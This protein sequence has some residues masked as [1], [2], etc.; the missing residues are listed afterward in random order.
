MPTSDGNI[1]DAVSDEIVEPVGRRFWVHSPAQLPEAGGDDAAELNAA[2]DALEADFDPA[3]DGPLGLC[4]LLGDPAANATRPAAVWPDTQM[5]FTGYQPDG[6]QVRIR[7]FEDAIIGPGI[8]GSPSADQMRTADYSLGD[9]YRVEPFDALDEVTH[10][11]VL[12]FWRREG[13]MPEDEARRRVE[14]VY[15]VAVERNEGVVGVSTAYAQR[16]D[17][18]GMDLLYSRAFVGSEHRTSNIA[19]RFALDGPPMLGQRFARGEDTR[20]A[21]LFY[22]VE[23]QLL[24]T[25]LNRA[26]WL[27]SNFFFIGENERGAHLRIHYFPGATIPPPR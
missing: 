23:N 16:N 25:S 3:G 15:M 26:V 7:Y 19:S 5:M 20:G 12:G 6:T 18:L 27:P 21:G 17:Q 22:E 9:R 14:E 8:P 2:F 4:L 11:H 1:A 13:A 10:D 24:K